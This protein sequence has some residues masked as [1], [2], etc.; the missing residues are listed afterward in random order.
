M[1]GPKFWG[2]KFC[3]TKF[4]RTMPKVLLVALSA[5]LLGGMLAQAQTFKVLVDAGATG[6][7]TNPNSQFVTQGRTGEMYFTANSGAFFEISSTGVLKVVD[8]IP[9]Y[10]SS[11]A[12]LGSDGNYYLTDLNG[13]PG[14]DCGFSGCGQILKVSSAGVQTVLYSFTGEGDG[15][16]PTAAPI[17]ATN[18]LFY[19]TA[20]SDGGVNEGTAYSI[21]SKGAFTV[22]HSFDAD[23]EGY[24]INAALVEGTDGNFYGQTVYGGANGDG[25]IFKMTPTGTV[26]VLHTFGGTD[27]AHGAYALVQASDGNF[28]GVAQGG[29][30]GSG[31]VYKITSGGTYTVLYNFPPGDGYEPGS[32]LTIGSDGKLYGV[33]SA[34]GGGE[35]GSLYNITT[36]GTF[37]TLYT[38]C[39]S[40]ACTDGSGPN[41]QLQQNTDGVFYGATNNGGDMSCGNG[42]GCGVVYSLNMGLA[43][44]AKL[45]SKAGKENSLAGILGQGFS[46]SSVVK[47]GGVEATKIALTGTTFIN[48]TVPAGALTGAVTITTG[49]TT[50]TAQ[51]NFNVLPTATTF[52]PSKG[53]VDTL[54]TITG[55]GLEQTTGVTFNGASATFTVVS[56]TEVTATVPTGATTGTI[57]VTTKGGSVTTTKKF[58]VD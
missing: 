25:T 44:F 39:A 26:T 51:Q 15:S 46:K 35:Y 17:E 16:D 43:P 6:S 8:D 57:A 21:T 55:T 45:V 19:G 29:A 3:R 34:G 36:A 40:G 30:N 9:N 2:T 14:G 11:G 20:Q 23:T 50:L 41:T 1:L 5:G 28:Y 24:Q 12:T 37:K 4:S 58:T 27:G 52:T 31:V 10:P 54:V 42:I 32:T 13:G 33:T 56:D 48:A 7:T 22:L 47:F 49:T 18:G 53:P 38:F